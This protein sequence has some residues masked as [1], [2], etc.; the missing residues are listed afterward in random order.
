MNGCFG[1]NF[2]ALHTTSEAFAVPETVEIPKYQKGHSGPHAHDTKEKT[3]LDKISH[4]VPRIHLIADTVG[5]CQHIIHM[6]DV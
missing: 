6:T 3:L 4:D 5:S 2:L 1:V